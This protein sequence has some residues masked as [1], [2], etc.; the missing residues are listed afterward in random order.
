MPRALEQVDGSWAWVVLLAAVLTQGLTLGFPSCVGIF[1]TELQHDFQASNSETSWFP[2]I[3]VAM[4]H[5]GGPVCSI[6]VGRFGCRVTMMLGAMLASLGMVAS[7]FSSTLSQLYFT[8]GFITGLG[9]SFSFL[10]GITV[11]GLYFVR[12]RALANALASAGASLGITLWPLLSRYLLEELGWRGSFLIFG[13]VLLHGCICGA[14]LRPVDTTT[15]TSETTESAPP[16]LSKPPAQSCLATCGQAVQRYLAFDIL[17]HNR[18]YCVYTVGVMCL[19]M[20]LPLPQIFLVPYAMWHGVDEHRAA[21]LMS[22]IGLSNIV[23]RPVSGLLMG[24]RALARYRKYLFC[25]A[26][27]LNGLTNLIGAASADFRVLVAYCL[28]YSVSMSGIGVLIFQVLMEIVAMDR[29]PS[30]LGLST[31]LD[32]IAA[33]ISPPLAGLLLDAT[34]NF[35]Y[36]FYLSSFILVLTAL[37]MGGSFY[38]LQKREQGR[39]SKVQG[40]TPKD[41]DTPEKQLCPENTNMTN[42]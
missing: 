20:G 15:S 10:S 42:V 8:A 40:D 12:R 3:L 28:L 7:S 30:A 33:L 32:G 23:L 26:I 13:G 16:P 38:V 35:S 9:M 2:S 22:I 34:N 36:L 39:Q 27:L 41:K 31:V 1:F 24:Y 11:L 19:I 14:L 29:F 4:L 37:F 21:L 6:L 17:L 25:L 5:A 18:A